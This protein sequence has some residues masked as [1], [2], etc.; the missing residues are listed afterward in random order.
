M[1]REQF[2]C[3][4][5]RDLLIAIERDVDGKGDACCPRDVAHVVLDWVPLDDTPRRVRTADALGV[6]QHQERLQTREPGGGHLVAPPP[7]GWRVRRLLRA[8]PTGPFSSPAGRGAPIWAP[9]VWGV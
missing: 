3:E 5:R 2:A 8:P 6:V 9:R 1:F 7:A 4:D